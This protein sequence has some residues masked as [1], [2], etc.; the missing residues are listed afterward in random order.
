M[1]R[2]IKYVLSALGLL[3]L[4]CTAMAADAPA[5]DSGDTAWMLVST[6]LVLLMTPGLAF[7]YAGMVRSKNAVSTL[8]QS[9]IALGVIGL[10]WIV[11]GFSLAFSGDNSGFIGDTAKVMLAGVGVAP[12]EGST[13]PASVFMAFQM[14]FAIITPALMTG[15]FAERVNFKAWL[16]ILVLWSLVVYSPVAHWVW[17]ADGWLAAKGAQDFAGGFVVHM[18][19]GYSALIAAIL[20]G[21]RKDFGSDAKPYST[22]YVVLG[23]ALLWF[24]WFGF[25]AGSALA[26]N[27]LAA[28]A[29]VNTFAAAALAMLAWTLTDRL[30]DGKPTAMGGCIGVVAGLVAIT[31][32]AGYVT[33]QSA[34]IIGVVTGVL[35]NLVARAVKGQF[36]IDDSLDV[37]ACHGVGGTIGIV[38]TGLLGSSAVHG[39]D[40]LLNGGD[41]LFSANLT[42]V[43]AVA[44]YSMVATF[45]IIK[46]VGAVC[47]VRVTAKEEDQGL[48]ASQH[49]EKI[50]NA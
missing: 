26:A 30:K 7:F 10:L 50:D 6:A 23:T 29:F 37:F 24:G 41:T 35:C 40:G 12:D 43:V 19:A 46:V 49:G 20:F 13:I 8:Y 4:P 36:K 28:V 48:D 38:M 47:P 32:A 25:N 22:G 11:V 31:P 1:L 2:H 44:V 16:V 45:I 39:A 15:A 17:T 34:I 33:V 18:T 14:M 42:G 9:V 3:L 27:G 5:I 21:K